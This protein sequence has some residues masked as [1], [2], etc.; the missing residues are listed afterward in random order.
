MGSVFRIRP[1]NDAIYPPVKPKHID[2]EEARHALT[3]LADPSHAMELR[4][5]AVA[6]PHYSTTRIRQGSDIDGLLKHATAIARTDTVYF[7]LNPVR[8][9]LDASAS[10]EDVAVRRWL[11][12]D[13]DPIKA[14]G[15]GVSATDEEKRLA[16]AVADD[17]AAMLHDL[18]FPPLVLVDSGNGW[19]LL[20]RLEMPNNDRSRDLI[21]RFLQG[22]ATRFGDD[23]AII[24]TGVYN[25]SRLAKLPGTWARKGPN[26]ADRPHRHSRIVYVPCPLCLVT[27]EMLLRVAGPPTG[28]PAVA[29]N[30]TGKKTKNAF[31]VKATATDISRYVQGALNSEIQRMKDTQPGH[32]N[33]QL[34][35]SAAALGNFVGAKYLTREEVRGALWAA[36]L[37]SGCDDPDKDIDCID[38]GIEAGM[39]TPRCLPAA[40]GTTGKAG[41]LPIPVV[42]D[43]EQPDSSGVHWR[44]CNDEEVLADGDPEDFLEDATDADGNREARVFE[45]F[46]LGNLLKTDFPEPNWIVPGIMSEGLNILAGAPKQGKSL[47]A[48]NLALT[49]AG[50]GLAL[51]DIKVEP[52]DVLYLSLE[53]KQ[54]RVKE[55]AVKMLKGIAGPLA[56]NV[57]KRLT[58]VTDW[59]RQDEGGL[60][61]VEQF[62]RRRS[63]KPG[64]IIVDVW[65]RFAPAYSAGG[66]T[67]NQDSDFMGK[68]KKYV[69]RHGFTALI[70]HHTRKPSGGKEAS[71]YVHEVSGTMGLTGVADGI[72]VLIRIREEA[73]ASL[74]ITG[75]DVAEKEL[76]LQFS[77]DT[78]TWKSMGTAEEHISGEVQKVVL[79]HL[80]KMAPAGQFVSDIVEL[81]KQKEDSVRKALKRLQ[82]L[83]LIR[84]TGNAWAYPGDAE[85][86]SDVIG[87]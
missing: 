77:V 83:K 40:I 68:I 31:K 24:D 38:R 21:Q 12:I 23:R 15:V 5:L 3:L 63:D 1:G 41:K 9:D 28:H 78:L 52:A 59:P 8:K 20:G 64:L 79:N 49:V 34:R 84:R 73:Q 13:I 2:I 70:I 57:N 10:D 58:V 46:S 62:W 74:H 6:S 39:Q 4:G 61:M 37:A 54:R 7:V 19:Y 47:M 16:R 25:A 30:G 71:D 81:V 43:G 51:G 66:N 32:L 36:A 50:G 82:E 67:Y 42:P 60:Q 76:V 33:N 22:L 48:L 17:V 85:T 86:V 75:R 35:K 26:T 80:K 65:N 69:D 56:E 87:F 53:D 29:V 18:G 55:R 45:M 44:V 14:D 27:E 11:F 72:L